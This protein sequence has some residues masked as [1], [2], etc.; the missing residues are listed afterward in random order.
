MNSENLIRWG[1][2]RFLVL[3]PTLFEK[4]KNSCIMAI[5][6]A[7]TQ[8]A[9]SQLLNETQV[10][11]GTVINW[12][13]WVEHGYQLL[14][15]IGTSV[16]LLRLFRRIYFLSMNLLLGTG[17]TKSNVA[18]YTSFLQLSRSTSLRKFIR[19][20]ELVHSHL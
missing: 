16:I 10:Q 1:R 19:W 7:G 18:R 11:K 17:I 20:R 13:S 5:M 4:M 15:W 6:D 2:V 8:F 12:L 9:I 14:N 3:L